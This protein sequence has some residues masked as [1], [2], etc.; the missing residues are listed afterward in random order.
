MKR[1]ILVITIGVFS[2]LCYSQSAQPN[3]KELDTLKTK[4]ET[5]FM[6]DQL[7]RRLYQ[8]AEKKFGQDSAEMEYFWKVVE[9]QDDRIELEF[10]AI[11]EK[12][13]WLG[14]SEVGRLANT[15][16]FSIMQHSSIETKKKYAPLMKESVLI[17]ESQPVQYAR[18]I[19]RMLVNDNKPQIYGSQITQDE[20]GNSI[21]FE[22]E[23]P[24]LIN[25]RRKEIGLDG[26]ENF[27][28]QRQIEW[29]VVQKEK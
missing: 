24:E 29:N 27:A 13:G 7:F 4:L 20:T 2:S 5:L 25:K 1:F 16:Q 18:L 22:I 11:I 12:Y 9:E 23:K 21:F 10:I 17:N 26:I 6:E 19:D 15:A 3:K 28:K 14:I 8:D